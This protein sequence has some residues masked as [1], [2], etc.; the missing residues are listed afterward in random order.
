M[1]WT[2]G[3]A[4]S[5]VWRSQSAPLVAPYLLWPHRPIVDADVVDQAGEEGRRCH[6][7][8]AAGSNISQLVPVCCEMITWPGAPPLTQIKTLNGPSAGLRTASATAK[9]VPS[10]LSASPTWPASGCHILGDKN[11]V[12][13]ETAIGAVPGEAH[14]VPVAVRDDRIRG[15]RHAKPADVLQLSHPHNDNQIQVLEKAVQQF[16]DSWLDGQ[17]PE[18]F[19]TRTALPRM[20]LIFLATKADAQEQYSPLRMNGKQTTVPWFCEMR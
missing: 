6:E 8:P 17:E 2:S 7:L 15:K 9:Y 3:T 18:T 14:A 11:V 16:V 20:V 4:S 1:T 19:P 5:G 13:I 10:N 12:Y